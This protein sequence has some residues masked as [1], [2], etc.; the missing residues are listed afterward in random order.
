MQDILHGSL[1]LVLEQPRQRVLVP[2]GELLVF[3]DLAHLRDGLVQL[4]E[5]QLVLREGSQDRSVA[6]ERG[7]VHLVRVLGHG[8]AADERPAHVQ[9]GH[10]LVVDLARL[11]QQ[12]AH[13]ARVFKAAARVHVRADDGNCAVCAM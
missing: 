13:L 12:D 5:H 4:V 10:T 1:P 6:A 9:H 8:D 7:H 2:V 3:A 11:G